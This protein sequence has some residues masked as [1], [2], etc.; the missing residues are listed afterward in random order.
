[1][2]TLLLLLALAAQ[3]PQADSVITFRGFVQRPDSGS[4]WKLMLVYPFTSGGMRVQSVALPREGRWSRYVNRLVR[5]EGTVAPAAVGT[6]GL[7]LDV[8]K[9]EEVAPAGTVTRSI[10]PMLSQSAIVSVAVVPN[11]F[12]WTGP[13]GDSTGVNPA[14]VY[15]VKNLGDVPLEFE[16]I[17]PD[18]VCVSVLRRGDSRPIWTDTWRGDEVTRRVTVGLG[19]VLRWVLPLPVE[20]AIAP[21]SY[22]AEAS[23]CGV[24]DY[25]IQADFDVTRD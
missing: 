2:N 5:A 21:G 17:N 6:P 15:T 14:I 25:R 4:I 3:A 18:V 11:K 9:M 19:A 22:S 20:A 10:R 24:A 23:L 1:M 8:R 7:R 12:G 13:Q 16:F